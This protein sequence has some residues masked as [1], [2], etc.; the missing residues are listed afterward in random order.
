MPRA[1]HSERSEA[2]LHEGN[3]V[4]VPSVEHSACLDLNLEP[5][6]TDAH[7]GG[8]AGEQLI[9]AASCADSAC[10]GYICKLCGDNVAYD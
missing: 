5:P 10:S 7:A 9:W 3:R 2:Q 1:D 8:V 6:G 4:S